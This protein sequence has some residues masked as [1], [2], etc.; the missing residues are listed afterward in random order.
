MLALGR[1][2]MRTNEGIC[3]SGEV[4]DDLLPVLVPHSHLSQ[5]CPVFS[6]FS[7]AASLLPQEVYRSKCWPKGLPPKERP[8]K[9]PDAKITQVAE[10]RT[11]S[12]ETC[13]K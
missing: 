6:K 3:P 1:Q 10:L 8:L 2:Q 5:V 12:T 4:I 11:L 9:V 13:L 7:L